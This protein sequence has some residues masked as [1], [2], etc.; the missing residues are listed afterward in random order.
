M[1]GV[2]GSRSTIDASMLLKRVMEI[3][4]LNYRWPVG[5]DRTVGGEGSC[6]G[7][8]GPSWSALASALLTANWVFVFGEATSQTCFTME[9]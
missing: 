6:I 2:D 5:R 9:R 8:A 4:G 7:F 1:D 3:A